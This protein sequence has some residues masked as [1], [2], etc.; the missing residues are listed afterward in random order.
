MSCGSHHARNVAASTA[1][2][3]T[4]TPGRSGATSAIASAVNRR[5]TTQVSRPNPTASSRCSTGASPT[6]RCHHDNK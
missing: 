5:N 1:L 2:Q 4:R 6:T 3:A